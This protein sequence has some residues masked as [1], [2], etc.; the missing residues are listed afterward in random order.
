MTATYMYAP[1]KTVGGK[2]ILKAIFAMVFSLFLFFGA[3]EP[4]YAAT[5]ATAS[6]GGGFDGNF[7]PSD[8]LSK[9]TNSSL[10]GWFKTIASWGLWISII[11]LIGSVL[12]MGGKVWYIPAIIILICLFG[13][14]ALVQVATWAGF[15]NISG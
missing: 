7:A 13:E 2:N 1:S 14:P 9:N 12:F 10:K 5:T 4:S 3:P 15:D 6:S 11:W 8:T